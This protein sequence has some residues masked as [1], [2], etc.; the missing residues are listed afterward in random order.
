MLIIRRSDSDDVG[1]GT[2]E[3]PGGKL[4]FEEHPEEALVREIKEEVGLDTTVDSILYA[5]S[6]MSNPARQVIIIAYRCTVAEGSVNLSDEHSEHLWATK[7]ELVQL[8]PPTILTD[9][10]RHKVV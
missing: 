5:S 9:F 8:L 6:F 4:D 3:T 10:Q 1:A 7:E 2:W